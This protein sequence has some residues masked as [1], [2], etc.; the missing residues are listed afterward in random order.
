[1]ISSNQRKFLPSRICFYISLN[2]SDPCNICETSV[3]V[4]VLMFSFSNFSDRSLKI[5][6]ENNSK[7][8]LMQK[9][10]HRSLIYRTIRSSQAR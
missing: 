9:F 5:E 6:N 4:F 8:T 10:D 2:S 1:M 3:S 7:F